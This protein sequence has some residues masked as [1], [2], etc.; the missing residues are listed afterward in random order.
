MI[1]LK[2]I[3]IATLLCVAFTFAPFFAMAQNYVST[4]N[5]SYYASHFDGKTTAFG[6]VFNNNAFTC[7]HHSLPLGTILKVTRLDKNI[8]V[9]VRVNDRC[10][11]R[12]G[13]AIDLSQAAARRLKMIDEGVVPVRVQ[14][15]GQSS[16][17]PSWSENKPM[18]MYRDLKP[19][20]STHIISFEKHIKPKM[21]SSYKPKPKQQQKTNLVISTPSKAQPKPRPK[22]QPAPTPKKAS[23]KP[24]PKSQSTWKPAPKPKTKPAPT[25]K[26]P[27][28]YNQPKATNKEPTRFGPTLSNPTKVNYFHTSKPVY[29][30]Q[31]YAYYNKQQGEAQLIKL[32]KRGLK[33]AYLYST[34]SPKGKN[35]YKVVVA[36][37]DNAR[38]VRNYISDL[39]RD[40]NME[41]SA[42]QI[43]P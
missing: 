13:F 32:Q 18:A 5:A 29:A 3:K 31:L 35:M 24:T 30:I 39:K 10:E 11:N 21:Y 4:G 17:N 15:I 25:P 8:W 26:T 19:G 7:A 34:K 20:S 1:V 43:Y 42:I 2:Q 36:P 6:E 23:S 38:S 40:H 28:T 12:P 37:F 41:G 9:K 27:T 16:K 14:E 33:S 22:T